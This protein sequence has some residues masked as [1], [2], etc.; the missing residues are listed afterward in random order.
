MSHYAVAVIHRD[1][2][3]VDELLAPY[4]ENIK[5]T[6]YIEYTKHEAIEYVR[7]HWK[8]YEDKS[9]SE[10]YDVIAEDYIS[11]DLTDEDGNLY[12]TYNPD[13]KW[14]WYQKGGGFSGMLRTKDGKKYDEAYIK[15]LDFSVD[16]DEYN[17]ALRF[18]DVVVEHAPLEPGEK[19][20]DFWSFY[21]ENYFRDYYV[22]RENYARIRSSFLTYAVITPNGVW[23]SKGN[24]GWWGCSSETPEESLAWDNT[25]MERFI[26][27]ADSDLM[28][29]IVDCHI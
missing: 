15:D 28:I 10:C 19:N 9:D 18:W 13:S 25:F 29:T 23:H 3:D 11:E 26:N 4:D 7:K 22:N 5:A 1:T 20:D 2:Q 14:D 16:Q 24:M 8:G 27:H 6:P 17:R 12:S 21:N